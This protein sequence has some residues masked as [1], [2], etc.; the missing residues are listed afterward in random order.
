MQRNS[1][2]QEPVYAKSKDFQDFIL[3][4]KSLEL[5]ELLKSGREQRN[6]CIICFSTRIRVTNH[7][8]TLDCKCDTY[9]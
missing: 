7:H 8:T 4:V 6:D 1:E 5:E 3:P 2:P 9:S